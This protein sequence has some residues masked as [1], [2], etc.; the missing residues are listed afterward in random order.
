ML[1][2]T[3]L[4]PKKPKYCIFCIDFK[5]DCHITS[6]DKRRRKAGPEHPLFVFGCKTHNVC[7]T[8]YPLGWSQYGRRPLVDLAPDGS[9]FDVNPIDACDNGLGIWQETVFG[10]AI[11]AAQGRKWPLTTAGILRATEPKPYGVFAT[12]RRHITG[13]MQ[14]LRLNVESNDKD[15]ELI[16]AKLPVS[17]SALE[18]SA[19]NIRDGPKLDRWQREGSEGATT[20][21]KLTPPRR[22]LEH[23]LQ[24]GADLNFWGS[25]IYG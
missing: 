6:K 21:Q 15:R 14:L 22:W 20:T 18:S 25:L 9:S 23:L 19:V 13:V 2:G 10:A 16:A 7:F 8:V 5:A 4:R 17:F 12:Q 3:E 11:D 1:V 24:L